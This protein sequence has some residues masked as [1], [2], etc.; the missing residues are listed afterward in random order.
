MYNVCIRPTFGD[1]VFCVIRK[2]NSNQPMQAL[3]LLGFL[4]TGLCKQYSL[5]GHISFIQSQLKK[6]SERYFKRYLL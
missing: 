4:F 1:W 3:L 6:I 2:Y 5:G